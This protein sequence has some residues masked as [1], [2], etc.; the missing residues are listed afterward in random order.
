MTS[1][2]SGASIAEERRNG[3]WDAICQTDLGNREIVRGKLLGSLLAPAVLLLLALPAHLTF[4]CLGQARLEVVAGVQAVL[5]GSSL[6]VAAIGVVASS[7]TTRALHAVALEAAVV[8]FPWFALLDWLARRG[9]V[10]WLCRLLHPV[11]HLEWLLAAGSA[12][13]PSSVAGRGLLYLVFTVI[14]ATGSWLI[15]AGR[16]RRRVPA[17]PSS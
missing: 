8:L 14:V 6:A 11:R 17:A 12:A 5:A 1:V 13:T 9:I 4:A 7:W 3:T 16:L 15:A 10:P 2:E